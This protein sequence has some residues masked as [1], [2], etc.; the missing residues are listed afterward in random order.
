MPIAQ[1]IREGRVPVK[2]YTGEIEPQARLQLVNISK[3]PIVHPHVAAMPDVHL[4]IGATV[5]SVIPTKQAIIPAAVGVD[6]GCGMMAARLSL[7]DREIDEKSLTKVFNQI[8]RDV[9]VGFD[10]HDE[11]D[12][13]TEAAKRFGR[14]LRKVLEKHPGVQ[15]RVGKNSHWTRQLGTLGGGNHFIEVCLDESGGVWVM[16]H[17]GS[18]GIGNAIGTYFIELAKKDSQ[19][20]GIHVPDADLA[21]FPE[22][23]QHFDDYVE[24]VGWAQDYARANR[25]EMMD[26]VI[27]A[28]HR[29]LPP[30][31][32]MREAVNCHHNYV[33]RERHYG[34]DVW[35]TRKGAIR[36]REGEL[37]IIPG[38]MGARSYIVRGKGRAESFHSCAHG[39]G[40]RM[41]RNAAQKCFKVQDLVSQTEGVICRKDRGVIDEIPG[42]YK[43]IDEVMAN[44]SD[45]V[46]V[47][48]TLKQV[49]CVKG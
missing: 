8:S 33:E 30:F 7:T 38:S 35:L 6:I 20:N 4:G 46:E 44:Q 47:V 26:L 19:R 32:V 9:P 22:G 27:E 41:S 49:L 16:L 2:V 39:A 23:A 10:Q 1:E 18:R 3:L 11:R 37:G 21:Y 29:H 34:E 36:A 17:S 25:E 13:R 12:A 14:G 5:G 15:K 40:R 31:E 48:H 24:A 42:A 28:M 43:D 45:L